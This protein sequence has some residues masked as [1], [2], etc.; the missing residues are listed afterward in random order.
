MS[1][2]LAFLTL[3]IWKFFIFTSVFLI[4]FTVFYSFSISYSF[5]LQA[6]GKFLTIC[7]INF[8]ILLLC[9]NIR[10]FPIHLRL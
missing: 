1:H 6:N 4:S 5:L 8:P 3:S 2:K 7:A 10:F 9:V